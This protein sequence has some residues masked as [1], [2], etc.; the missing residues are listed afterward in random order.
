MKAPGIAGG[1]G[2][3]AALSLAALALL[4]A[5][6]A[7]AP[8]QA[9]KPLKTTILVMDFTTPKEYKTTPME[10]HGW[11]FG[12]HAHYHNPNAGSLFADTLTAAMRQR[13]DWVVLFDRLH[14]RSYFGKKRTLLAR[15]FKDLSDDEIDNLLAKVPPTSFAKELGADKVIVGR[16]LRSDTFVQK[17][18]YYWSSTVDVE[19][20]LIDVDS[21][22][23]VW[24][25]RTQKTGRLDSD[26][27]VMEKIADRVVDRMTREYFYGPRQTP[28]P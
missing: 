19:C 20:S 22:K 2:D 17:V 5:G 9:V 13:M 3:R 18:V 15:E 27:A 24:T 26:K 11:W 21:G 10:K 23:T 8:N 4:A 6:C 16:I 7:T 14:V 25:Y 1:R 12:S 28:A